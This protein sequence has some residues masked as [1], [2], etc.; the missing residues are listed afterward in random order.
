MFLYTQN[1]ILCR[2]L[3]DDCIAGTSVWLEHFNLKIGYFNDEKNYTPIEYYVPDLYYWY[4]YDCIFNE[5]NLTSI[6]CVYYRKIKVNNVD[7]YVNG[8]FPPF[9]EE[10]LPRIIP[11]IRDYLRTL[12]KF[13]VQH[14]IFL[15]NMYTINDKIEMTGLT[16]DF[17]VIVQLYN[18]YLDT[19]ITDSE[20]CIL[21][22]ITQE[23]FATLETL[24]PE[25]IIDFIAKHLESLIEHIPLSLCTKI[26][27][28][29]GVPNKKRYAFRDE[30]TRRGRKNKRG[31]LC[32]IRIPSPLRKNTF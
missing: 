12:G 21:R 15:L 4:K 28:A 2:E 32:N 26:I 17:D 6:N 20:D 19:T 7:V 25:R 23:N 31:E 13:A 27:T 10:N 18:K 22:L 29:P 5:G 8:R 24:P 9:F 1:G 30:L 3:E 11:E 16:D 14:L